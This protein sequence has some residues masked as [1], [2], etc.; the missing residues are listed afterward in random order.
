MIAGTYSPFDT[1]FDRMR[2]YS[3]AVPLPVV[4]KQRQTS[5]NARLTILLSFAAG[6]LIGVPLTF[7]ALFLGTLHQLPADDKAVSSHASSAN[8]TAT[9]L[10]NIRR[11]GPGVVA[12]RLKSE[13]RRVSPKSFRPHHASDSNASD[14]PSWV[15]AQ[16]IHSVSPHPDLVDGIYWTDFAESLV[17]KGF[18]DEDARSWRRFLNVTEVLKVEEG[19]G[20][21]QNRLVTFSE[22]KTSCCRYRHNNDQIQGEIFSFYLGRLLDIDNLAPSAL[23]LVDPRTRQWSSAASQM[24]LAR[25]NPERPAVLT[26]FVEHLQPA[27]VPKHFRDSKKRRLHPVRE[28]L[29]NLTSSDISELVQW[30]DL[31]LFDYLTANL[32]RVVNN[33]YNE[34]WNPG[35]MSQPTHNLAKTPHGLLLFLDNESGLLHGYRLLEKYEHFHRALLDVMC[36]FRERTIQAIEKLHRDD[37]IER[38]LKLA[39]VEND[40][41]MSD[42]LPFL[43]DRSIRTLKERIAHIIRQVN[44]CRSDFV[45]T[46]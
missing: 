2:T 43:P 9:W 39:F 31:V 35:M 18:G 8:P 42:W 29:A 4:V 13:K 30:T 14:A 34:R 26:Q 22:G 46:G 40:P 5:P 19:C 17:P 44:K 21:M 6:I 16:T 25:W 36:I 32:D 27:F 24:A 20:R 10:T 12:A 15:A 37:D 41:G 3:T 11:S 38:R 23:S 45:M 28:D 7:G 33:M 1:D